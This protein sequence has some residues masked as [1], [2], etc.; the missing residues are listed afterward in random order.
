MIIEAHILTSRKNHVLSVRYFAHKVPLESI[1]EIVNTSL[2]HESEPCEPPL[3]SLVFLSGVSP[4]GV[5]LKFIVA[6]IRRAFIVLVADESEHE[7]S[8][9][10]KATSLANDLPG[11]IRKLSLTRLNRRTRRSLEFFV[12]E[13]IID[14]VRFVLFGYPR[15]GK[16]SIF[17]LATGERPRVDY[18]P[19]IKPNVAPSS[20]SVRSLLETDDLSMVD[21]WFLVA[22]RIVT[23]YD[24]PGTPDY[25][26]R[27][28]PYLK[29]A[30]VGVLVLRSVRRDILQARSLLRKF[31]HNLPRGVIAI[32]NYQ[33]LP[34][35][36]SP[37]LISQTLGVPTYGMV[38]IDL[39]RV[40]QLRDIF[41]TVAVTKLRLG[42]VP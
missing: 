28:I 8:L 26:S 30:D 25:W 19:T 5:N 38:G 31:K 42:S 15:S 35:A 7:S 32:A 1:L 29:R 2:D 21:E 34:G 37:E 36:P 24:L 16:T 40:E 6:K 12:N 17:A 33:D 27:W 9:L 3:Q 13:H 39:D 20:G 11:K 10:E 4:S 41:K 23:L 14:Y 18:F 22:N